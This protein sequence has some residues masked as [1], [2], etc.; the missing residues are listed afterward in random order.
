MTT[1]T[2]GII[3][4]PTT[5]E[6]IEISTVSAI[7]A[8]L[9]FLVSVIDGSP[10]ALAWAGSVH[11]HRQAALQRVAPRRP[12]GARST[13]TPPTWPPSRP[14]PGWGRSSPS[15]S[16]TGAPSTAASPR[17]RSSVR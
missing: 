1:F 13:S 6:N 17:W 2:A 9:D 14:C 7:G 16:S 15:G 4:D 8:A 11:G 5:G 3:K 10:A 12:P